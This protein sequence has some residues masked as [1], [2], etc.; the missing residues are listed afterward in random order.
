M[1]IELVSWLFEH[2][3]AK[4]MASAASQL[5]TRAL[6]LFLFTLTAEAAA[7]VAGAT[8]LA[9]REVAIVSNSREAKSIFF[10]SCERG[11]ASEG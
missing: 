5:N 7:A 8:A 4:R 3:H 1:R 2:G 10:F 11:R 6:S 9:A